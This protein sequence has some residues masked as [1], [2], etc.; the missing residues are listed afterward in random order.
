MS[1]DALNSF[2]F[3]EV[4]TLLKHGRHTLT[5]LCILSLSTSLSKLL[6]LQRCT[7]QGRWMQHSEFVRGK[8]PCMKALELSEHTP[9]VN[10]SQY[11][12]LGFC[13]TVI[14]FI[15][16]P[17]KTYKQLRYTEYLFIIY[18]EAMLHLALLHLA[19][20]HL[21]LLHLALLH[22]ALLSV[23]L[24]QVHK[25]LPGTEYLATVPAMVLP[26]SEGE[27]HTTTIA[28]VHCRI[29]HPVL[30]HAPCIM[31]HHVT[32]YDIIMASCDMKM[33]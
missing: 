32:S 27:L 16:W 30:H 17:L 21:A 10:L 9:R 6:H 25:Y 15:Q 8:Y 2:V 26:L 5:F 24:W 22:L 7:W 20:L 14:G 11:V 19:L 3:S 1:D 4:D 12:R 13:L 29:T 33:E 23:S 18:T 31:W 28:A